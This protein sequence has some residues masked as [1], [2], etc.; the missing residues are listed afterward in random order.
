MSTGR[1]HISPKTHAKAVCSTDK[2]P[3]GGTH[4][5]DSAEADKAAAFQKELYDNAMNKKEKKKRW[6]ASLSPVEKDYANR[7]AR[8]P[9]TFFNQLTNE[10]FTEEEIQAQLAVETSSRESSLGIMRL[11]GD[12]TASPIVGLDYSGDYRYEEEAGISSIRTH[13]EKGTYNPDLITYKETKDGKGILVIPNPDELRE[14]NK[15]QRLAKIEEAGLTRF[16]DTSR[17][18]IPFREL[19][20][21]WR[22]SVSE[23]RQELKGK[24][25]PL[26]TKKDDLLAAYKE[27]K[28]PR[29]GHKPTVG[30]FHTG[31]ALTII[32][33]NPL[34]KSVMQ[35]TLESAQN[36]TLRVGA[37][38]NPFSR[39]A[40]FYDER[41]ISRGHKT[42]QKAAEKATADSHA[43]ISSVQGKME[44]K[45]QVVNL[46]SNAKPDTK[47]GEEKYFL[48]Y[49]PDG[50][51][52][53][54]LHSAD[55]R[56]VGW[57]NK[58][59]LSQISN[60]DFSPV[61]AQALDRKAR[62]VA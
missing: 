45:G 25:K 52:K 27:L 13:L 51:A 2:C 5:T 14:Y 15:E 42:Y 7:D 55:G 37:S 1:W 20:K 62:N 18:D 9:N 61:V 33:D 4:Y 11:E 22:L 56:I 24:V 19:D 39:G 49:K 28:F 41:D 58:Q 48:V 47:P 32:T 57:F 46:A 29:T 31:E 60:G 23:L 16:N 30:E 21:M 36:K 50:V 3:Y 54:A 53:E 17:S 26:P 35:K 8:Q 34:M 10:G 12:E 6:F 44:S 38:S 43:R 40:M 59:E